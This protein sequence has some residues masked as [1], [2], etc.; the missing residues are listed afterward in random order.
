[1]AIPQVNVQVNLAP[2]GDR[3]EVHTISGSAPLIYVNG[4]LQHISMNEKYATK[5][6]WKAWFAWR[7]VKDIH[8]NWH[9]L[10]EVYRAVG[11][12][13]V[14]HDDWTWYH[15]GTIFDVLNDE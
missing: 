6:S 10:E 3:I 9:W 7:P 8:G 4:V 11:N 5:K 12:T 2:N 14:D 13:Y 15:Y 1:M